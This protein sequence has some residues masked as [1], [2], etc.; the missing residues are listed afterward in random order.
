[1]AEEGNP[2]PIWGTC[3]GY[4]AMILALSNYSL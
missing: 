2:L 3:L 4:E 1:M